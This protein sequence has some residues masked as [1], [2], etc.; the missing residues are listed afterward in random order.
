MYVFPKYFSKSMDS[1][2]F[3]VNIAFPRTEVFNF[4]TVQF[5]IFSFIFCAFWVLINFCLIQVHKDHS[6]KFSC[7]SALSLGHI[8]RSMSY[9][10]LIFLCGAKWGWRFSLV[11]CSVLGFVGFLLDMD[12]QLFQGSL[13]ERRFSHWITLAPS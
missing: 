11:F 1:I 12:F 8:C 3:F 10:K 5:I 4:E 2:F 6:P 7:K 13:L 9:F